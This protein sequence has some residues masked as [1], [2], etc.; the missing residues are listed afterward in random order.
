MKNKSLTMFNKESKS[1]SALSVRLEHDINLYLNIKALFNRKK[2]VTSTTKMYFP[3]V[4]LTR[5]S[6]LL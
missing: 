4:R 6:P 5:I 3:L 2:D 1:C